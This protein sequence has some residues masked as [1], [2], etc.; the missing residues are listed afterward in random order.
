MSGNPGVSLNAPATANMLVPAS[1]TTNCMGILLPNTS[2]GGA[3]G[4]TIDWKSLAVFQQGQLYIPQAV[5]IDA[6]GLTAPAF[7]TFSIP[8]LNWKRIIQPGTA[9]TFQFPALQDLVTKVEPSTGNPSFGTFWYNWPALPDNGGIQP[10]SGGA[11]AATNVN[12]IS[13]VT[14]STNADITASI[15]L[16]VQAVT[17]AGTD[18]SV[19]LPALPAHLLLTITAN[20]ARIGFVVQNNDATDPV[21]VELGASG[22]QIILNAA[23]GAGQGGGY[24]D[25]TGN[26][27]NGA[28]TVWSNN[29]S[30]FVSA[31]E[32]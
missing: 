13:S 10:V 14:L 6:T 9:P 3:D 20:P 23:A 27:F 29:A 12:I 7:L 18:H 5:T 28:I 8:A 31:R 15:P 16:D 19:N 32:Y 21:V 24:M 11:S 22:T 17:D 26:P 25:M 2:V 1:G 4:Y 30:A